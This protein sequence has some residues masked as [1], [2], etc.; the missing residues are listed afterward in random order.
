S[1]TGNL[2]PIATPCRDGARCSSSAR[3]HRVTSAREARITGRS[4]RNP[5]GLTPRED[6]A[7]NGRAH[8]ARRQVCDHRSVRRALALAALAA[9]AALAALALA[10]CKQHRGTA[11]SQQPDHC[12]SNADCADGWV[13]LAEK[14]A[15]PRASALYSDPASA[16]T[17]DKVQRQLEQTAAQHEK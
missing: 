5:S 12:T 3:L 2:L 4:A 8:A 15:D 13:C 6:T 11:A 1:A 17:P 9:P 16:V 14:C 7:H 10:A